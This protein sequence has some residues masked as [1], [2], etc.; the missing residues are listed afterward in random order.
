[1]FC[2]T[3]TVFPN[4]PSL[5]FTFGLLRH[6]D[7]CAPS[8][9]YYSLLLAECL[10]HKASAQKVKRSGERRR[11]HLE[12]EALRGYEAFHSGCG[13]SCGV[14]F[15]QGGRIGA[16]AVAAQALWARSGRQYWSNAEEHVPFIHLSWRT[17]AF[18]PCCREVRFAQIKSCKLYW[19]RPPG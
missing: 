17:T 13:C 4:I 3:Q 12:T 19:T 16:F 8:S 5:P 14:G 15:R 18:P 6:T 10:W 2:S 11:G 1:M 7:R 9:D